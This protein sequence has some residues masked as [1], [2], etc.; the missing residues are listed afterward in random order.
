[1]SDT[2]EAALA[3]IQA[4]CDGGI[5]YYTWALKRMPS[6]P[7]QAAHV[8]T[9]EERRLG[10]AQVLAFVE[11]APDSR[12]AILAARDDIVPRYVRMVEKEQWMPTFAEGMPPDPL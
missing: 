9:I 10:L 12:A 4:F 3:R 6:I 1:M 5:R 7:A 2:P 8:P 11:G